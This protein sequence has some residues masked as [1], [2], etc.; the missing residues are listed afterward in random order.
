MIK[1]LA[2]AFVMVILVF[3][4]AQLGA[5]QKSQVLGVDN[6]ENGVDNGHTYTINRP[7]SYTLPRD[8]KVINGD[9]IV[10]TASNV[11]LDLDGHTVAPKT[12]GTGMGIVI[13]NV[14]NVSVVNG[15]IN[16]FKVNVAVIN[17]ENVSVSGLQITGAG[18][19]PN[20]GPSEIGM[21]F[22]N[23]RA[24]AV[25]DNRISSVNLGIFVRG[26]ASTG[27]RIFKNLVVG[28]ADPGNNLLGIC[29]NPAPT[30]GD[31]GPRGD[32]VYNNHIARFNFAIS[33]SEQSLYN[34]F[35]DN[36]L[37]SFTGDFRDTSVL[38]TNGGTNV[39]DGNIGVIIPMETLPN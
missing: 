4:F 30:G 16:R 33:I 19:A 14:K 23:S 34:I 8:L 31:A 20:N 13:Q 5:A 2:S 10:I 3:C 29:Y 22:V 15:K 25:Y 26:G 7:G 6:K 32:N 36:T 21:M 11:T 37:A 39:S 38:T 27:N 1:N 12:T 9:G 28:G 18:L 17:S 24:S 35:N